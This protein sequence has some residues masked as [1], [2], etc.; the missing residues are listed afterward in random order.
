M[1]NERQKQFRKQMKE[2]EAVQQNQLNVYSYRDQRF[3]NDKPKK[4]LKKPML[5]IGGLI[6]FLVLLW[7]LYALS[8]YVIPWD[9]E[10]AFVSTN[11]YEVHQFIQETAAAEAALH[12]MVSGLI[13]Q[14]NENALTA[15]H[16][17]EVQSSIFELQQNIQSSDPRFWS[18]QA[19][20]DAQ[21]KL[22]YQVA[23][24][25]KVENANT[26]QMELERIFEDLT[27]LSTN[28]DKALISYV[29]KVNRWH[30]NV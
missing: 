27:L 28:R 11:Q 19:Y 9:G 1:L 13:A 24:V 2:M 8:S 29:E 23:N 25:L 10:N 22:A 15:I 18:M 4:R 16:V 14:H 26:T 3:G 6:S 5:Q 21:F 30:T 7:N 12:E 20:I 17:Q